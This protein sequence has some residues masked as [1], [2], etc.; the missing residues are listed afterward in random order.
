M[1]GSVDQGVIEF[2]FRVIPSRLADTHKNSNSIN[3]SIIQCTMVSFHIDRIT[4]R[5]FK[6]KLDTLTVNPYK[7]QRLP[8]IKGEKTE[9]ILTRKITE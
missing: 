7:D 6:W 5:K 4:F 3:Y 9:A 2:L 8:K 1:I